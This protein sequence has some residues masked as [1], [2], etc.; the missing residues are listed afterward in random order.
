[1]A[2]EKIVTAIDIGSSWIRVGCALLKPGS[3][4]RLVGVG[5]SPSLGVR[6]GQI[7]DIAEVVTSVEEAFREAER[8]AKFSIS[9][10]VV[11]VGGPHVELMR[12]SGSIAVSRADGE[13]AQDDINRV[14]EA[15]RAV[16][17]P[18]NKEVIDIL[19]ISYTVD[20]DTDIKDPLGMKGVRLEVNTL[21]VLAS[22]PVL[23]TL[24]RAIERTGRK[25]DAWVY[26]PL[27][28]ARAVLSKKQAESGLLLVNLGGATTTLSVLKERELDHSSVLVSGANSITNDVAIGLRSAIDVAE[29]VKLEYGC[30]FTPN[31]SKREQV[32]LAD[33]GIDDINVSRYA[34]ARIIEARCMVLCSDIAKEFKKYF[35]VKA[36]PGGI[37][38]TGGGANLAGMVELVKRELKLPVQVGRVRE[39]ESELT[40][41]F[42]PAYSTVMGSILWAYD[43]EQLQEGSFVLG[44]ERTKIWSKVKDWFKELLP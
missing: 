39:I 28:V 38:L 29:K 30:C 35:K 8:V 16:S 23:K 18:L 31:V 27:A 14:F 5:E 4:P 24:A 42:D 9:K 13:I 37:V 33:W 34:L 6:R 3:P 19:P 44:S 21:L 1:M 12:S 25:V 15:A 22:Q 7:V 20:N 10:A 43:K 41:V 32:V 11:A 26:G 36:L 2:R 17:L 40:E